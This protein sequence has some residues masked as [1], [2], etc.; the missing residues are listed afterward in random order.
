MKSHQV[1]TSDDDRIDRKKGFAKTSQN[2]ETLRLATLNSVVTMSEVK[3][4]EDQT[5][6]SAPPR[7]WSS[8]ALREYQQKHC[9]D[10]AFVNDAGVQQSKSPSGYFTERRLE[11][12]LTTGAN[13]SNPIGEFRLVVDKGALDNLVSFCGSGIKK[14]NPTQFEMRVCNFIPTETCMS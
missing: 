3:H 8:P 5:A 11:Y 1:D 10:R 9:L 4:L 14:I 13:W 12:V 2:L 6:A 7:D